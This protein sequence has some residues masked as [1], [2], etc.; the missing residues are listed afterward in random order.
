[1]AIFEVTLKATIEINDEVADSAEVL[2]KDY[3]FLVAAHR[4]MNLK[5]RE[6]V[7]IRLQS[8]ITAPKVAKTIQ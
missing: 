3:I 2:T 1:M 5:N 6:V 7:D 4:S 8:N